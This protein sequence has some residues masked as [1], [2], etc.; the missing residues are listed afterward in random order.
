MR[1]NTWRRPFRFYIYRLLFLIIIQGKGFIGADSCQAG[2]QQ[3]FD[4]QGE[5]IG[6]RGIY[7]SINGVGVYNRFSFSGSPFIVIWFSV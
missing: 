6:Y 2:V 1:V 4:F 7:D 3:G 5:G